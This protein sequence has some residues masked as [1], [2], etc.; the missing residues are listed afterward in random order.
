[1]IASVTVCIVECDLPAEVTY[2][3]ALLNRQ[4]A[5]GRTLSVI[6]TG[7]PCGTRSIGLSEQLISGP[8]TPDG[9]ASSVGGAYS[10]S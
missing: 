9:V 8:D 4:F 10:F 3:A 1:M 7:M 5:G 2:T 6:Y